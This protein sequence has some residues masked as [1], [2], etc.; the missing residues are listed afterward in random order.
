MSITCLHKQLTC[1]KIILRSF[2]Y[3]H[4]NTYI[5]YLFQYNHMASTYF[6]QA[7]KD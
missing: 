6:Q 3:R 4:K 2:F 1:E 7:I 5:W